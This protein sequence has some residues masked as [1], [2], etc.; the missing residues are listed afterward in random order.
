M[1]D[2]LLE[3]F[4]KDPLVSEPA[5]SLD[6][7]GGEEVT[8]EPLPSPRTLAAEPDI[9]RVLDAVATVSDDALVAS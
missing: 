7:E 3:I 9:K 8:E 4:L 2:E 5:A 6:D 1:P